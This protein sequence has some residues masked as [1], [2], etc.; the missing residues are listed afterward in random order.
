M[1]N[2]EI[3]KI[4]PKENATLFILF[5]NGEFREFKTYVLYNKY[6]DYKQLENPTIF[7]KCKVLANY[8][9]QW[10]E[11]LDLTADIA[12]ELSE[13]CDAIESTTIYLL[14]YQIKKARLENNM[15]QKELSKITNIDQ[16]E[17]SKIEN[18]INNP[19]I[20][21]IEKIIKALNRKLFIE[22]Q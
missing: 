9:I 2:L 15:S 10:D 20:D 3:V 14:G 21:Y 19:S 22:L 1:K 18:G 6:P 5:S 12:Y 4:Y 16:S 7:N 13:K 11:K 8:I 17:I